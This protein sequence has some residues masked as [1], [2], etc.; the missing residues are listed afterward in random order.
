MAHHVVSRIE[1]GGTRKVLAG[2]HFVVARGE[3]TKWPPAK[4]ALD[5]GAAIGV[6]KNMLDAL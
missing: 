4:N 2:P 1:P 5:S 3:P 6:A